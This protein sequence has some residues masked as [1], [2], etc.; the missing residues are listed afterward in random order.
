MK[1]SQQMRDMCTQCSI[2]SSSETPC[3]LSACLVSMEPQSS[4]RI[5]VDSVKVEE[6]MSSNCPLQTP[7]DASCTHILV[8]PTSATAQVNNFS[9]FLFPFYMCI[10]W[11]RIWFLMG[12][13]S[14]LLINIV[15]RDNKNRVKD[16]LKRLPLSF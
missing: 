8:F 16:K 10:G 5:L 11:I 1:A 7:R 12:G 6:K 15:L 3:I 13:G 9:F 2:M 14:N 4:F